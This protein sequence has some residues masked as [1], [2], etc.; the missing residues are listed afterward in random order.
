MGRNASDFTAEAPVG[1]DEIPFVDATTVNKKMTVT[2]L[3]DA[4]LGRTQ[5]WT[6][7]N[8]FDVLSLETN[9]FGLVSGLRL[10][11]DSAQVSGRQISWDFTDI[12]A[13][14]GA[15]FQPAC[16]GGTLIKFP[17][18]NITVAGVDFANTFTAAQTFTG[19]VI[20]PSQTD[21]NRGAAG[22]A[23]RIIFNTDDG[24]LNI[25]DGSNWTLPDG[26]TT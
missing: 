23:G 8:S 10:T 14:F 1:T 25:D 16:T 6:G 19:N 24:Q 7:I 21:G 2:Q 17:D 18:A 4:I 15:V 26:T 13:N 5:S 9:R 3:L 22:T 11:C 12:S 20:L